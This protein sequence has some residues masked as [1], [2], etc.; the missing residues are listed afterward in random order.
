MKAVSSSFESIVRTL[1]HI[2][3]TEPN[4][5]GADGSSLLK[6]ILTF[7]FILTIRIVILLFG[8]TNPLSASLQDPK[9]SVPQMKNI[10]QATI[11]ALEV[12]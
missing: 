11:R 1:E 9:M 6:N 10:V 3:Q 5:S 4:K 12:S 2:E 8:I 7:E